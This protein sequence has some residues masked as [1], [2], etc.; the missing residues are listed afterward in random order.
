M[1]A[2]L[3]SHPSVSFVFASDGSGTLLSSHGTPPT[4]D[5][6]LD[7][8]VLVSAV[9]VFSQR[10]GGPLQALVI[11]LGGTVIVSG[12]L[13]SGRGVL[14]AVASER[15]ALGLLLSRVHNLCKD[16]QPAGEHDSDV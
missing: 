8:D 11:E 1:S 9:E 7:L 3:E 14:G 15:G 4:A 13:G 10:N 5:F 2:L 12:S 6:G 16:A